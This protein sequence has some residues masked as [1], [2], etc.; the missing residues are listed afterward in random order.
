MECLG[1]GGGQR[2]FYFMSAVLKMFFHAAKQ[3]FPILRLAAL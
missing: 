3:A 2:Q 1:G